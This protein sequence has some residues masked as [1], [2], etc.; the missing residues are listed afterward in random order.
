MN[1]LSTKLTFNDYN[2]WAAIKM[3]DNKGNPFQISF[4]KRPV[5]P[6]IPNDKEFAY[7][8]VKGIENDPFKDIYTKIVAHAEGNWWSDS[9]EVEY[10]Q[11]WNQAGD[12][13]LK[14]PL[15]YVSG[16]A[17]FQMLENHTRKE[18][19]QMGL[20][21]FAEE[22]HEGDLAMS[23]IVTVKPWV[24]KADNKLRFGVTFV[25]DKSIVVKHVFGQRPEVESR[26]RIE[27][28]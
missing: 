15:K 17:E 12:I 7:I 11:P 27:G 9:Q 14:W 16:K 1:N 5:L 18:R 19:S 3:N 10:T 22:S 20:D 23:G 2:D 28:A 25:L 21:K 13:G 4:K 8:H 26:I 24:C 6:F